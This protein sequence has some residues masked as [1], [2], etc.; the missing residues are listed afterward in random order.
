MNCREDKNKASRECD[1]ALHFQLAFYAGFP[2]GASSMEPLPRD[3]MM[4]PSFGGR[5]NDGRQRSGWEILLDITAV[6]TRGQK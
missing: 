1:I 3:T 4:P 5:H 2:S 6:R